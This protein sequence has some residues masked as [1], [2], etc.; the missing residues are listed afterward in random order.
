MLHTLRS[1]VS[2]AIRDAVADVIGEEIELP[3]IEDPPRPEM[4]DLA[5]A[6]ALQLS[7]RLGS[8][9]RELAQQLI[10]HLETT[11]VAGVA[12]WS[13]AGPGFLNV[14][15][16]RGSALLALVEGLDDNVYE[17]RR[18]RVLIE[19]TS[20]NPNKAAHVG[21]LRNAC[22][23]DTLAKIC[24]A[25]GHTVEVH[26]YIDDTGVQVAD[27]VIG[28][29]DLRAL[30]PD[31]VRALP[32]P[33]DYL[34]WD[35]YTEVS[36]LLEEDEALAE[37][38]REVLLALEEGDS[39]ES[40]MGRIIAERIVM[41][42]LLTMG[43]LGI[44]YDLLVKEADILELDLWSEAFERLKLSPQVAYVEEGKHTGCW[45][46]RLSA[47]EGFEQL[48]EADKVLVRSNG[49]ATYVAK[50]IAHH[51]WK[52]GLL[53]GDF[54]YEVVPGSLPRRD[55]TRVWRTTSDV[56]T[57]EVRFGR[58]DRA[59]SVIDVRQSY[60]QSIV[61]QAFY[62]IGEEA[63]G[64]S[65]THFD[66]EMVA[67]SPQTA[68]AL[69]IPTAAIETA[70]DLEAPQFVEMSGRRGYGVKAD[71]LIDE[72]VRRATAEVA[73]RN[74]HL[75]PDEKAA[76]GVQIAVGAARYLLLR[77]AR[78][79]VIVFDLDEAL[80]FEG[81]TGPYIQYASVRAARIFDKL[82]ERLNM[83]VPK[84]LEAALRGDESPLAID[85][86]AISAR[87]QADDGQLWSLVLALG[88]YREVL[89]QTASS[90]E[91]SSLARYAFT[92]AQHFSRFY[93][94]YPILQADDE[95]DRALRVLVAYAFQRRLSA[96]LDLL[97][98]PLP[99]RM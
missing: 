65:F 5:C 96:I 24:A 4:G 78:N 12:S 67:L 41:R 55:G 23:G 80:N 33:F 19:H 75:A 8:N 85:R 43:R 34:C 40:E 76:I 73:S 70:A 87:L 94:G 95:D 72:L 50:D 54:N 97:G 89:R 84:A 66:Y 6:I 1:R 58:A 35:L 25:V 31:E 56:G 38:R 83:D 92:L 21:H 57:E 60:L 86:A 32:E 99:E 63:A 61:E 90:L 98:I 49:T 11:T 29:L 14:H 44:E 2:E 81:E 27:V 77:Y 59:I 42:H 46:I 53:D 26:N 82:S 36:A 10:G 48:E 15:L 88:A 68:A 39:I 47:T 71:D 62:L 22:M 91:I 51:F 64:K 20:V 52:Y 93:H 17:A 9:P 16:D 37:R 69:G 7:K 3:Q 79:T 74:E 13:I 45:V 28:F 30:S 18:S